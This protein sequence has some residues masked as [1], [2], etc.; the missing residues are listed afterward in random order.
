[1]RIVVAVAGVLG[2]L[3]VV[4][5]A[6]ANI[7][8]SQVR[9]TAAPRAEIV[10]PVAAVAH[11]PATVAPD[12]H[13]LKK[14]KLKSKVASGNVGAKL[15]LPKQCANGAPNTLGKPYC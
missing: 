3:G 9:Q 2:G 13:R 12:V 15:A 8:A 5:L 14:R 10:T 6:M 11:S 4:G 7:P 1:M